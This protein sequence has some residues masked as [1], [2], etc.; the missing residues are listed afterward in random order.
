MF[1]ACVFGKTFF[2]EQRCQ[3]VSVRARVAND[4]GAKIGMIVE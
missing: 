1:W 2:L 3:L 4:H